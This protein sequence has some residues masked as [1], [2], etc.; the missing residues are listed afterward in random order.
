M[1]MMVLVMLAAVSSTLMSLGYNQRKLAAKGGSAGIVAY[2]QAR[3]GIVD[4]FWRLQTN[5]GP[6]GEANY[7]TTG[8]GSTAVTNYSK[9]ISGIPLSVTISLPA[10]GLRTITATSQNFGS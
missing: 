9:T 8:A 7:F 4:A 3:A 10:A 1:V 2:Y 5:V 6:N